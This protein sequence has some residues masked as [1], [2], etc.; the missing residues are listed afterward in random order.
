LGNRD[1]AQVSTVLTDTKDARSSR[2][3]RREKYDDW[4]GVVIVSLASFS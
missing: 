4:C 1:V 3:Q 2:F